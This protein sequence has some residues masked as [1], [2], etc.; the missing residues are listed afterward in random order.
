M[1][2]QIFI[3]QKAKKDLKKLDKVVL[4]KIYKKLQQLQ[5]SPFKNSRKLIS[6]K[7]GDYRYRIGNYRVIFNLK[8]KKITILRIGH[9]S[10]IYR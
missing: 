1:K 10:K 6:S 2:Y 7:I 3:T 9:R 5:Y 8:N 4:K